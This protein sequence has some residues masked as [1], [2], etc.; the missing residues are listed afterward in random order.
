MTYLNL[1]KANLVLREKNSVSDPLQLDLTITLL[2]PNLLIISFVDTNL[3]VVGP[4]VVHHIKVSDT[5]NW[6]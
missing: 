2:Q 3:L 1:V 4:L 5:I 6:L